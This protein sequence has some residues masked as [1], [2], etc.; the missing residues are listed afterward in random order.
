[1]ASR[2]RRNQQLFG[3]VPRWISPECR[4]G[5]TQ[6]G[7]L[8][9]WT[10]NLVI[11]PVSA[12][13][14]GSLPCVSGPDGLNLIAVNASRSRHKLCTPKIPLNRDELLND[15]LTERMP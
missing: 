4:V 11:A 1:M 3:V 12:I 14:G 9:T 7:R 15:F 6:N 13:I 10:G 5:R 2:E 8:L